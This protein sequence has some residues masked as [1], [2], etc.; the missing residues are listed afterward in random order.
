MDS[1]RSA[2]EHF[3]AIYDE[4]NSQNDYEMWLG[5]VLLPEM[6]KHGLRKGWALDVGCGT[7]RAFGPLLTRGWQL[8]GCD[9][10]PRM[11][12]EAARKFGSQVQLLN[13]DARRLPPISPSPSLPA[14]ES[15]QLILL[16]NDVINY[17]TEDRDLELLFSGV[18]RNLSRNRGLVI[19]DANTLTQFRA[20]YAS[21]VTDEVEGWRWQGLTDEIKPEAIF[22]GQFS[23]RGITTHVHRQRHWAIERVQEKLEASGLRCLAALGQREQ[24]GRVLLTEPPSE[25]RDVKVIYIVTHR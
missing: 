21:H 23:G 22:Q 1:A 3:A 25:E 6:E 10:A 2:N 24:D 7:G 13:L 9:I 20:D 17:L 5:E 18:K 8:I 12:T 15:F 11:L 16:L 4:W 14:E 19:F